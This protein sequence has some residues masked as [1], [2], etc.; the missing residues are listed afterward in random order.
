MI[1]DVKE[2]VAALMAGYAPL[3]AVLAVHPLDG[4]KPAIIP[5]NRNTAGD[6]YPSVT[7]RIESGAPEPKLRPAFPR[8]AGDA[9][10]DAPF[11]HFFLSLEAW[12]NAPTSDN[13][14]TIA[15]SLDALFHQTRFPTTNG[16]VYYAERITRRPEEWD[17]DVNVWY[18]LFRYRLRYRG[19]V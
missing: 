6:V 14:E 11:E 2:A 18:G 5:G 17:R 15:D 13:L 10:S 12:D 19:A 9:R 3:T 4:T 1:A 16:L 8:A 7:Y